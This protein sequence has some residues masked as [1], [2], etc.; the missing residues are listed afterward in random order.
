MKK[1]KNDS[2]LAHIKFPSSVVMIEGDTINMTWK[3]TFGEQK[4]CTCGRNVIKSRK[5]INVG[6]SQKL[7]CNRKICSMLA[8]LEGEE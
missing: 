3:V 8:K 1:Q 2:M 7:V 5:W 4:C 6:G